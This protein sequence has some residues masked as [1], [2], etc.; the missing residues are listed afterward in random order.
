MT[1]AKIMHA[2]QRFFEAIAKAR[3]NSV[4]L[5]MGPERVEQLGYSWAAL[6]HGPEAW[7]WRQMPQESAPQRSSAIADRALAISESA[8]PVTQATADDGHREAA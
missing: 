3:V 7:S 2:L 6:Q 1:I 8:Q 5:G 4:L